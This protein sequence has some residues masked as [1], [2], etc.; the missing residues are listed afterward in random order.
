MDKKL[1]VIRDLCQRT[2]NL[3]KKQLQKMMY[4]LERYGLDL[5]LKYSIHFYGPYC[6]QLDYSLHEYESE[7]VLT[8]DTSGVTHCISMK[9]MMNDEKL[10]K[11]EFEIEKKVFNIFKKFTPLELEAITTIDYVAH[12]MFNDA[13]SKEDVLDIVKKIKG[14]KFSVK[15]LEKDYD[16]LYKQGLI[17]N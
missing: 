5:G 11:E 2:K 3:G 1:I 13:A 8:I 15:D 12:T 4:L 10:K 6:A 14:S 17:R 16:T 9:D 7:G